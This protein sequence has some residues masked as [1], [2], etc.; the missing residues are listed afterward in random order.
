MSKIT[1]QRILSAKNLISNDTWVT[2]INNND[3][4]VGPSGGG[5]TRG[6]VIPNII[7]TNQ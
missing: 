3:L 7:H 2:G 4:I 5:K 1:S 6:Y